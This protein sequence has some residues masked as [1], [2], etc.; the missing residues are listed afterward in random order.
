MRTN[1]AYSSDFEQV[2]DVYKM[3]C[4]PA[5]FGSKAEAYNEW[6]KLR[7]QPR[8]DEL[9]EA[10]RI[11]KKNDSYRKKKNV[12]CPAWK[13]FCRWVKYKCWESVVEIKEPVIVRPVKIKEPVISGIEHINVAEEFKKRIGRLK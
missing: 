13:H 1:T 3:A 6:V 12:F 11:E 10:I 5:S 9:I 7:P 4:H 2:W 8:V